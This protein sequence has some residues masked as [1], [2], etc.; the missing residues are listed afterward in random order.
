ML[1]NRCTN[2]KLKN[3]IYNQS[4]KLSLFL[5][6]IKNLSNKDNIK[7]NNENIFFVFDY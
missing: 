3:H 5:M 7:K 4:I 6:C 2:S 1:N